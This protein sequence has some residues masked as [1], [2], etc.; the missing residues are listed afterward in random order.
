[1]SIHERTPEMKKRDNIQG[2]FNAL[3][4]NSEE[5][6]IT[7]FCCNALMKTAYCPQCGKSMAVAEKEN[8]S[9]YPRRFTVYIH[10]EDD[11]ELRE[12]VNELGLTRHDKLHDEIIGC[13]YEIALGFEATAK[14]GQVNLIK[15][16]GIPLV[17]KDF[18]KDDL[19]VAKSVGL[20][21][22]TNVIQN[23][24][25]NPF[26]VQVFALPIEKGYEKEEFEIFKADVEKHWKPI[27]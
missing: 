8:V 17:N 4:E 24:V 21:V 26:N 15:V 13:A 20:C 7:V 1:M 11:Y 18:E 2:T 14:D 25:G 6:K 23:K 27:I 22:I 16:D 5:D 9:P 10:E 12:L 19:I 3:F